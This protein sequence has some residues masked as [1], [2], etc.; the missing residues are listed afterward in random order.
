M[1]EVEIQE[2]I[3]E[4]WMAW[5]KWCDVDPSMDHLRF[6]GWLER[7][8]SDLLG[9]LGTRDQSLSRIRDWLVETDDVLEFQS[10]CFRPP[11]AKKSS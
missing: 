3:I 11:S 10:R 1:T 8:R 2:E 4:M 9:L 7:E 6:M 5:T